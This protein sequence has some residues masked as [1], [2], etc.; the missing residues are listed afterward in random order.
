MEISTKFVQGLLLYDFKSNLNATSSGRRICAAFGGNYVS[1]CTAQEWF[2]RF[3]GG[4]F[5]LEDKTRSG[6]HMEFNEEALRKL[7]EQNSRQTTQ[8][9]GAGNSSAQ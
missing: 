3:R 7:L 6:C 5:S 1:E 4:N 8:S 2:K 9:L